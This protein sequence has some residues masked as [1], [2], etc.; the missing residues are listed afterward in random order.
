MKTM[1]LEK[2]DRLLSKIELPIKSVHLSERNKKGV[3]YDLAC[4]TILSADLGYQIMNR[5]DSPMGLYAFTVNEDHDLNSLGRM[6]TPDELQE[7]IQ[8]NEEGAIA[9]IV[10]IKAPRIIRGDS[11]TGGEKV[12][13]G[14][15]DD[16]DGDEL[17]KT[18]EDTEGLTLRHS[19]VMTIGTKQTIWSAIVLDTEQIEVI[20]FSD[21]DGASDI[22]IQTENDSM[23]L[24][25]FSR[26]FKH[27]EQIS[28]SD[29]KH[30][31][32]D[33]TADR[34]A[35]L[36]EHLESFD[37]EKIEDFMSKDG[38]K[39]WHTGYLAFQKIMSEDKLTNVKAEHRVNLIG[40]FKN[41]I[42]KLEMSLI[43]ETTTH[44]TPERLQ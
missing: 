22:E 6:K 19:V 33:T 5:D 1:T 44:D 14:I 31:L 29:Y 20:A 32:A 2:L 25:S 12:I 36:K 24:N 43:E 35:F 27:N 7:K 38:H 23:S 4:I 41:L 3:N 17:I 39:G 21:W 30:C 9:Y 34:Q 28:F 26:L 40:M 42:D 15:I 11:Y 18:I 13:R 8:A 10:A 37:D 16:Y